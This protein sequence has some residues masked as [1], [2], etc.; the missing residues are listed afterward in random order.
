MQPVSVKEEPA[1]PGA[2]GCPALEVEALPVDTPLSPT[3][4]INSILQDEIP[5]SACT[6][7]TSPTTGTPE[8]QSRRR[9]C[10]LC[11]DDPYAPSPCSQSRRGHEHRLCQPFACLRAQTW[12]LAPD[13]SDCR[14]YRQVSALCVC[15]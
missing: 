3:T 1:S 2:D 8:H 13:L 7:A 15:V 12:S 4:F 11:V 10:F 6:S 9:C 5:L 14:L